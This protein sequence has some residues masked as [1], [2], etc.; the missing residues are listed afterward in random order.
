MDLAVAFPRALIPIDALP[1]LLRL[2]E[3]LPCQSLTSNPLCLPETKVL[4]SVSKVLIKSFVRC[5]AA[6]SGMFIQPRSSLT[7]TRHE[8]DPIKGERHLLPERL[9]YACFSCAPE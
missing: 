3:D 7:P 4:Q 9:V 5:R 2:S 8:K 1:G 6:S